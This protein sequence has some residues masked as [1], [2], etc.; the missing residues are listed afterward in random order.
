MNKLETYGDLK[1]LIKIVSFKRKKK[2]IF[3]LLLGIIVDFIPFANTFS[4]TFEFV[5]TEF[6]KS[7]KKKTNTWL[8]KLNIDD[9]LSKIID[10]SIET[11]FLKSI[12]KEIESRNNNE[13]LEQDFNINKKIISYISNNYNGI[14]ITGKDEFN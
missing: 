6:Q 14:K 3:K 8:D 7:D 10:D 12:V 2:R 13:L 4:S 5:K 1:K 9:D 11:N